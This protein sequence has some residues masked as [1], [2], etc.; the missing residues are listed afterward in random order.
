MPQILIVDDN[1]FN[2]MVLKHII[3][4]ELGYSCEKAL[5]GLEALNLAK[6][7]MES[8]FKLIFMDINMPIMDG[9]QAAS[10]ILSLYDQE[11]H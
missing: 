7:R 3:T 8:P 6:S 2:L 10:S 11:S 5:N 4:E 9:F 1:V